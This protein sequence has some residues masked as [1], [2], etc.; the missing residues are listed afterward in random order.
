MTLAAELLWQ[1]LRL[2]TVATERFVIAAEL[3]PVAQVGGDA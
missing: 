3:E 2:T 1:Q